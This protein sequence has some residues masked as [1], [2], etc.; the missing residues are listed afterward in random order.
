MTVILP[1]GC[2]DVMEAAAVVTARKREKKL[3]LTRFEESNL[4]Q[5]SIIVDVEGELLL[6]ENGMFEA[7]MTDDGA[8]ELS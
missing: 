2:A 8:A 1:V 7:M 5:V 4:S 3:G 6:V